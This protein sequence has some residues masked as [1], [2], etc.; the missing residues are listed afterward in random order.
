MMCTWVSHAPAGISNDSATRGR[1][2]R[3][4]GGSA[5]ATWRAGIPDANATAPAALRNPRLVTMVPPGL[6]DFL[7]KLLEQLPPAPRGSQ[8]A[9]CAATCLIREGVGA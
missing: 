9:G 1:E 4:V 7:A 3:I 5:P 2:G 8:A 6:A